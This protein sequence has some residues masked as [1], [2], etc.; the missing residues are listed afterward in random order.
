M[1][2][3]QPVLDKEQGIKAIIFLQGMANIPETRTKAERGWNSM[4]QHE[5]EFTLEFYKKMGGEI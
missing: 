3:K 1:A 5:K 2:E 4:S